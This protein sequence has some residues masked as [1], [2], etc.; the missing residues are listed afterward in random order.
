METNKTE[1]DV[2][3]MQERGKRSR[4]SM[5][6]EVSYESTLRGVIQKTEECLGTLESEASEGLV[7]VFWL[8]PL[9]LSINLVL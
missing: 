9:K 6:C 4:L 1:T 8:R 5:N 7:E 3:L 2:W